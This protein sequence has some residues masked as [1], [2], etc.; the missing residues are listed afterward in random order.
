MPLV[1]EGKLPPAGLMLASCGLASAALFLRGWFAVPKS[2]QAA[3]LKL[4]KRST[5]R[6][7]LGSVR[8][9]WSPVLRSVFGWQMWVMLA[10]L[11]SQLAM[12]SFAIAYVYLPAFVKVT[13]EPLRWVWPLPVVSRTLFR[14]MTVPLAAAIAAA[15]V[16]R[17][18]V[19]PEHP[20]T[21]RERIVEMA[22]ELTFLWFLM[23]LSEI[24]DWR[25]LGTIRRWVRVIPMILCVAAIF[26]AMIVFDSHGPYQI[27]DRALRALAGAL[28]ENGLLFALA[29][30]AP[31]AFLYL[32]AEHTFEE[33]EYPTMGVRRLGDSA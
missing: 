21:P 6:E 7:A 8:F 31:V 22:A 1:M 16:L 2:F 11:L 29:L 18:F 20:L 14:I 13:R 27:F 26:I 9:L 33:L 30:I 28:P 15:T 32:L 25:R 5:H 4:T 3:P 12:G 23:F 17:I 19:D 24:V 10:L